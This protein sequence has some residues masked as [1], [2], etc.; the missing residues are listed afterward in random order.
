MPPQIP[1]TKTAEPRRRNKVTGADR[2]AALAFFGR[3][4]RG[5]FGSLGF[6]ALGS[7]AGRRDKVGRSSGDRRMSV[8]CSAILRHY[9]AEV[10]P[11]CSISEV[12]PV[13]PCSDRTSE[14]IRTPGFTYKQVVL[15]FLKLRKS[16]VAKMSE[17][18]KRTTW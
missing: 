13:C 17:L 5:A 1:I 15:L 14:M 4:S 2:R 7:G 11:W 12:R 16:L 10:N 3:S 18:Q 6:F 9:L 8:R